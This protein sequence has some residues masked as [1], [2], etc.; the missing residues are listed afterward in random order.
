MKIT[1]EI[2]QSIRPNL[3][4][5][6]ASFSATIETAMGPVATSAAKCARINAASVAS[7]IRGRAP[8]NHN[9]ICPSDWFWSEGNITVRPQW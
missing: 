2:Q 1:L 7:G 5:V 3:P 8:A 6:L 4:N 9:P